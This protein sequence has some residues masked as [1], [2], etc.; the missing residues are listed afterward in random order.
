V[1]TGAAFV[2][3]TLL[4][5][6][7]ELP[8][9]LLRMQATVAWAKAGTDRLAHVVRSGMGLRLVDPPPEWAAFVETLA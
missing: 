6:E 7:V 3:G 4:R 9:G 1:Q 2:P 8:S 5:I